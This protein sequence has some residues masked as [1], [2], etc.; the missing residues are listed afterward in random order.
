[1]VLHTYSLRGT[2]KRPL[3]KIIQRVEETGADTNFKGKLH[4]CVKYD[5]NHSK[6]SEDM[7]GTP[8]EG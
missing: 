2:F 8:I 7:E 4:I 3:M 6:G 5:E 1:M